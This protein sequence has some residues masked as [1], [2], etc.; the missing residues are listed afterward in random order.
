MGKQEAEYAHTSR[1]ELLTHE[2]IARMIGTSRETVTRLLADFKKRH[3][4]DVKGATF[5]IKNMRRQ[6]QHCHSCQNGRSLIYGF[7]CN[8]NLI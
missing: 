3:F 4:I 5:P 7:S 6:P 8:R 1:T 2:E